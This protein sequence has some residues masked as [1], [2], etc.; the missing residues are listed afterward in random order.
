M[1]ADVKVSVV[2][3]V[4][5]AEDTLADCINSLLSL[6]YPREHVEFL[7]VDNASTDRTS[8]ILASYRADIKILF[9]KKK[10]AA[11]ARNTGLRHAR[12]EII[13]FI[14]SD[15]VADPEWLQNLILPL[16]DARVGIVGGRILA[17]SPINKI[18]AFGETIHD[19]NLSIN[20]WKPPHAMTANWSSRLSVLRTVGLFDETFLRGQDADLSYRIVQ[21][22]YQ[23]V[24]EHEAV[25]Y[26]RNKK[27]VSGLFM[28]GYTHGFHSVHLNKKHR[29]FLQQHGYRRF[30]KNSY[31]ALWSSLVDAVLTNQSDSARYYFL[32]NLGKKVGRWCGSLRYL[33][34]N[35]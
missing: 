24:Y 12:G 34:L 10:G 13:A 9:E 1:S 22:G 27:T 30:S 2:V 31:V 35:P 29:V 33:Y 18:E 7:L 8:T 5:N 28:E 25:V 23:L 15:C 32:F 14:D 11:A 3:P 17:Q 6:H 19:H 4:Y 21:A 16:H 20:A 26:H